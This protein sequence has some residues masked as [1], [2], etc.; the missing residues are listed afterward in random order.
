MTDERKEMSMEEL[1]EKRA[2]QQMVSEANA[3]KTV[4]KGVYG[5]RATQYKANSD[6]DNRTIIW[7]SVDILGEDGTRKA[8]SS[9]KMSPDE[10]RSAKGFLDGK[11]KIYGQVLK[12][13]WPHESDAER[14]MHS[15]GE[16]VQLV[17]Q[18][19]LQG[20]VTL[21]YKGPKNPETGW[22]EWLDAKD[23][24]EELEFRKRGYTPTNMVRSIQVGK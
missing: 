9:F 20:F 14:A 17:L 21:T 22:N 7:V 3:F 8:K 5:L 23:E 13:L 12:A 10:G 4:P 6:S 11:S 18:T 2:S 19:P 24:A 1:F 15:A 16:V